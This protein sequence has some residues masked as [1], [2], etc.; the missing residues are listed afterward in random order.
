MNLEPIQVVDTQ[1]LLQEAM[2][3]ARRW[4]ADLS[5]T[6]GETQAAAA[7]AALA[8]GRIE[9]GHPQGHTHRV[10]RKAFAANGL[11]LSPAIEASMKGKDGYAYYI[12]SVPTLLFPGRGAQYRLLECQLTFT[13]G[14]A[15]RQPAIHT[16][17]PEERWQPV[18]DWGGSLHLALDTLLHWGVE[19]EG[20]EAALG[21][22][23]GDLAGRVANVD[24]LTGFVE[25][26]PFTYSLGRMEIVAEQ[27]SQT[28]MW[29]LD[30]KES[31]R[32]WEGYFLVVLKAPK[33]LRQIQIQA[34]AQAEPSFS[35]LFA[36]VEHVFKRLPA[37]IQDII[38]REKGLP[39]QDFQP[40]WTLDLPK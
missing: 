38:R 8:N 27:S 12:I 20:I 4:E 24:A 17:F 7:F 18:L 15:A 5:E 30:S 16:I 35:W 39:L 33:H 31:I 19:G 40:A 14:K 25:I 34:A 13:T 10:R 22:L 3:A 2:A 9:L 26:A 1:P 36:Q 32:D 11:T 29:R 6:K 21:Q 37:K 23:R 28:A